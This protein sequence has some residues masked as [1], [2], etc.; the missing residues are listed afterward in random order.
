MKEY[1]DLDIEKQQL[2]SNTQDLYLAKQGLESELEELKA[3]SINLN[4]EV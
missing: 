1:E 4:T 2:E 3:Y